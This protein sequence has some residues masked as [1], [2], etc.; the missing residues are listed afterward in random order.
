MSDFGQKR[1]I[2]HKKCLNQYLV[3]QLGARDE[4]DAVN[5]RAHWLRPQRAEWNIERQ[6]AEEARTDRERQIKLIQ[7]IGA[8]LEIAQCDSACGGEGNIESQ[9]QLQCICPCA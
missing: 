7:S 8:K 9:L 6:I 5:G 3:V 1:R 2:I 4:V